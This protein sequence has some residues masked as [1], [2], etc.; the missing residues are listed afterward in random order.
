MYSN[1]NFAKTQKQCLVKKSN[2]KLASTKFNLNILQIQFN[3]PTLHK[4][5]F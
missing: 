2:W 5:V 1:Q 3:Y 4:N